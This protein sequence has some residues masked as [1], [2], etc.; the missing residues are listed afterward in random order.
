MTVK[1]KWLQGPDLEQLEP[2]LARFGWASL[3]PNTSRAI[4]AFEDDRLVGFLPLQ[5]F[6]HCEPLYVDPGFRGTGVAERL[7]DI[8]YAFMVEI[9]AR[10]F[11]CVADSPHAERIC[12]ERGM[13]KVE[14]PVYIA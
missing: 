4:A 3:N 6:P 12:I 2:I 7:A 14:S 1:Y 9:K 10:G 8:M 13:H 11:I 5:L